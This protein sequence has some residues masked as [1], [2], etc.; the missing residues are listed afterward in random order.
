M[1]K[2]VNPFP[3]VPRTNFNISKCTV[4]FKVTMLSCVPARQYKERLTQGPYPFSEKEV[5]TD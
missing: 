5:E 1:F 3:N 2:L 4:E